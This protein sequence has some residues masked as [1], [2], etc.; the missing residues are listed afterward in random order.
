[1][2]ALLH[3]T[4]QEHANAQGLWQEQE[5][6]LCGSLEAAQRQVE[7]L[8]VEKASAGALAEE[9]EM[10]HA[11]VVRQIDHPNCESFCGCNAS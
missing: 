4:Q 7:A 1:M 2:L 9:W 11:E 5:Q 8:R 6:R 3:R 10:R